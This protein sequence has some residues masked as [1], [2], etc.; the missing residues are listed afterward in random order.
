[1]PQGQ[2]ASAATRLR[3]RYYHFTV[4]N[5][6]RCGV[7]AEDVALMGVNPLDAVIRWGQ[8]LNRLLAPEDE[9]FTITTG[10]HQPGPDLFA[11]EYFAS[12]PEACEHRV[13]FHLI[14]TPAQARK[15][16][17]LATS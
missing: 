12:T 15:R 6:S 7:W 5:A 10:A 9:E 1:M 17:R 14:E 3:S 2:P 11:M 8:D 13:T 4:T 16:A